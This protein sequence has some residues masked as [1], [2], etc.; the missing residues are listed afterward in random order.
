MICGSGNGY[1]FKWP[2]PNNVMTIW[3]VNVSA[4][5]EK[6]LSEIN[7]YKTLDLMYI[8]QTEVE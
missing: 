7:N 8:L 6:L 5:K 2:I 4:N 3:N 1:F